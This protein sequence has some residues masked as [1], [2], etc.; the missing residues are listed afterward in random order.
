MS[1]L[2]GLDVVNALMD[3]VAA[4]ELEHGPIATAHEGYGLLAEEVAE[5]LDEIRHRDRVWRR[6]EEEAID[7]AVVALRIAALARAHTADL[8]KDEGGHGIRCAQAC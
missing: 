3:R 8:W 6:I 5:L 2:V 4:V 1:G 7:V